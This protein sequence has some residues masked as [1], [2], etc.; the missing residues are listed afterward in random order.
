M[1]LFEASAGSNPISIIE[2]PIAQGSGKQ[3]FKGS[4]SGTYSINRNPGTCPADPLAV[5]VI[6]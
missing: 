5:V 3:A 1:P 4:A 6:Y 2:T